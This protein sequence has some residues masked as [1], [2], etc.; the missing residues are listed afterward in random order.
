LFSFE[1]PKKSEEIIKK[2]AIDEQGKVCR[3]CK[4]FNHP[5]LGQVG[6]FVAKVTDLRNPK[7]SPGDVQVKCLA[8]QAK[9][10]P[11]SEDTYKLCMH[12]KKFN[13]SQEEFRRN[14]SEMLAT[15]SP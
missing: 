13:S 11:C 2:Q 12:Y 4:C 7:K 1:R 10:K 3:E 5:Y 8:N 6:E 15:C 9:H 14:P